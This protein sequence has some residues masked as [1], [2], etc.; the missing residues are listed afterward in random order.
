[1]GLFSELMARAHEDRTGPLPTLPNDTLVSEFHN[2]DHELGIMER[3]TSAVSQNPPIKKGKNVILVFHLH[4]EQ[5]LEVH[6][7]DSIGP[8]QEAY[9]KYEKELEGEA[10]IVL[11]KAE[12]TEDLKRAFQNYFTDARD[13]VNL[14]KNAARQLAEK[15]GPA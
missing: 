2:L 4:G 13:F 11:V 15:G 14:V 1:M 9:T 6:S 7:Y 5:K 8:A 10:D 12:H 3:L